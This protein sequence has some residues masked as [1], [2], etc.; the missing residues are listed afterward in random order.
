MSRMWF[1]KSLFVAASASA[2]IAGIGAAE[3]APVTDHPRLWVNSGDLARLRSWAVPGNPMYANGLLAAA[4]AAK[5]DVD[6]KWN[7]STGLPSAAWNDTGST[8]WEGE[9]TE[10]YAEMFAFMSLVDPSAANR[11]QWAMRARVM[12]MWALNQAALGPAANQPFRDPAFVS[13][14][15][16][17]AWGEAW[18]LTVDWIYPSLGAADKATIRKVFL[19]W[20]NQLYTV[21]NRAG[22]SPLLPGALNDPR[23]LGNNP[24]ETA[25]QQQ[26]DQIQLRWAANNYTIGE[27]RFL[28]MISMALDPA[29]DPLV[30]PTK[31]VNQIGNS[32]RS[33]IGDALQYWLYQNY[34]MFED[35]K[36]SAPALGLTTP[37]LSLGL[38]SGGLPV[39]GSLYGESLGFL[40]EAL[41]AVQSAGYT[42][43]SVW[44]PQVG[45][46]ARPF[47][48]QLIDG[49]YHMTAPQPYVPSA[50]S[51]WS[52]MGPVYPVATYGD[53]LRTWWDPYTIDDIGPTAVY[54]VKTGNAARLAKERWMATN[55]LQGGA[56]G[57]YD[58]V[59]NVWGN[60]VATQT[61]FY[62]LMFDPNAAPVTDPRPSIPKEFVAPAIGSVL[63]RT[64]WTPN[65]TW[66]SY[67]C[68]WETINHE[69]GDCGQFQ[70]YRKGQWLTK[71]WS[72]YAM[73]WKGYTSLYHNTLALQNTTP[74]FTGSI[75]D[76]AIA[77]GSQWNN[78]G[79]DGDPST[80]LSA[81]DNWAYAL[82]DMKNLYNHPDWWTSSSN[83]MDITQASR[84][85][86]W[87]NPDYVV[88]YDRAASASANHFKRFNLVLMNTP[89]ISGK[90]A[91]ITAGGQTLTVQSLMPANATLAEQ[92]FW[93]NDP[94]TEV[95][96]TSLLDTSYDRLVIED[97]SN[98]GSI[99]FLTV[100]QGTD[101]A[102]LADTA[103]AIHST[104]G[105]PF[106]G[107]YVKNVAVMFPVTLG[108]SF[109]GLSYS[110][111]STV[112]RQLITGL[113]PGAG[114]NIA[115][116]TS[117]STSTVTVT[118]G[119]A[120]V[121]DVGG[122]IA[123]GFPASASPTIGGS[124]TGVALVSPNASG[125]TSP[126]PPPPPP[127]TSP[128]PPPPPPP[129][130]TTPSQGHG[131]PTVLATE[132]FYYYDT[133]DQRVFWD[134]N[135]QWV[136]INDGGKPL[137]YTKTATG[138]QG[139]GA[140]EQLIQAG[141]SYFDTVEQRYYQQQGSTWILVLGSNPPSPP[142]PAPPPPPPAS[143]PPP[144][145]GTFP[146]QGHGAP[147]TLATQGFYY[148]DTWDQRVFWQQNGQWILI[149][150]GGKPLTYTK[151]ATGWRGA[152]APEQLIQPGAS[153]VD[154]IEQRSYVQQA[155]T[156]ILVLPTPGK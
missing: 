84:S 27:M 51:G 82:S 28:T 125:P 53:T 127:P 148:Y 101:A 155:S 26:N 10:A 55:V 41:L 115:I 29:D 136:L 13:F 43:T 69:S 93:T 7:W 100:L 36:V 48:D 128:P 33:Y 31:P 46:F 60:S 19:G 126:P 87:L 129:P 119:S 40:G 75:W 45:F 95:D 117:G 103:M 54:D 42:D 97:T 3:A 153:Y 92:H 67:R 44:G 37:N 81:N 143:P 141:A 156:W 116:S 32:M 138:W 124:V 21:P 109:T 146:S 139:A 134:H 131:A 145:P 23:G 152:G 112:T 104:G 35:P 25:F 122:V 110:V 77:T 12:L 18:A 5:A 22:Q 137:T 147:T 57:L 71:E 98:P 140:P 72:N 39:E 34:A 47:W 121:A 89:A 50:A 64:D 76:V 151:T 94:A 1:T 74:G 68:S 16:A 9:V 62:Y 144:P 11:T 91:R 105:S 108:Q 58:R 118:P 4:N 135:G 61:I 66:F 65:A 38:A 8:N 24:A 120:L 123:T 106:D 154:T 14:N 99:R 59:S 133:W 56:A 90:T 107:A 79:S 114:Y 80:I 49:K 15:R 130:G 111:P 2:L 73:D 96:A 78:G 86:V 6:A 132:G 17:N 85:I 142:P 30:D 102:V 150:D 70:F 52:F 149:N 63:A 113:T 88:V 20:A 83:A